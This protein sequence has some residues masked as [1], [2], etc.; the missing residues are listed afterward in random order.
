MPAAM[1]MNIELD[2]VCKK[3]GRNWILREFS[4]Q[5]EQGKVYAV[6][7]KNGS[8]KSTLLQLISGML[9]PSKGQVLWRKGE[10]VVP[11]EQW[12]LHTSLCSP[13]MELIGEMTLREFLSFHFSHKRLKGLTNPLELIEMLELK[14]QADQYIAEFS[15]GMQ[16][17]VKL[18]QALFSEGSLLLLDEPTSYLDEYWVAKYQMWVREYASDRCCIIA[19]N[20]P[21]EYPMAEHII[22]L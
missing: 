5:F 19:S 9:T 22:S 21:R 12:Y 13:G 3:Y 4:Q 17:R 14:P 6:T 7:G 1:P 2:N 11:K 15:S 8:G 16:Q 20:D 18:A 10:A